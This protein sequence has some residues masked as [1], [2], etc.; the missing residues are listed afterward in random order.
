MRFGSIL[1]LAL[2]QTHANPRAGF[3]E[4]SQSGVVLA[5]LARWSWG[6]KDEAPCSVS[7]HITLLGR[8][9]RHFVVKFV[10]GRSRSNPKLLPRLSPV[11]PHLC[12]SR[13]AGGDRVRTSPHLADPLLLLHASHF[14]FAL[15]PPAARCFQPGSQPGFQTSLPFLPCERGQLQGHRP[16]SQSALSRRHA[17][18]S[19]AAPVGRLFLNN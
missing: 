7:K 13:R 15:P 3:A 5:N 12:T 19:E 16:F 8:S 18:P 14:P 2:S 9:L 11:L 10:S 1:W 6:G 17:G 4:A